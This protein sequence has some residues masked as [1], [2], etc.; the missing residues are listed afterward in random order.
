MIFDIL[1]AIFIAG[2]PIAAFSYYLV[3]LTN[4]KVALKASNSKELKQE[5][6][7]VSITHDKEDGFVS[8]M[9]QKKFIKFGGGFYGIMAFISY[10]HIEVYQVI[11]FVRNFTSLQDFLD[12]IGF[13]MLVN[14]FIEAIMNLVSAFMWPIYWFKYLPIGSFWVWLIVALIAHTFATRF[15]LSRINS[16]AK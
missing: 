8:K 15:A 14:F 2:I 7:T 10:I 3:V 16:T 6:K 4:G 12:S 1:K 5:L 13:R 11:D 9:L